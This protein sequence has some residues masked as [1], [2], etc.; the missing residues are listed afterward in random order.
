MI[1]VDVLVNQIALLGK[2]FPWRK[3]SCCPRCGVIGD[4]VGTSRLEFGDAERLIK[5]KS[6]QRWN[7]PHSQRT[8][9]AASTIRSW[10]RRYRRSGDQL[11]ST[12][13]LSLRSR[14]EKKDWWGNHTRHCPDQK[15]KSTLPVADLIRF[16]EKNKLITSGIKIYPAT[17]YRILREEDLNRK[18]MAKIDRRRLEAKYYN[19]IWQ[20]DIMHGPQVKVGDRLRKSYLIAFIDDHSRLLPQAELYLNE[21]LSS[22]LDAFSK[23][24]KT[25]GFP[26]ASRKL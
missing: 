3:P 20:S 9:I 7:I 26:P 1:L 23:A 11:T 5:E 8:R 13:E 17:V 6:G 18:T 2:S 14:Q 4:L 10:V 16:L 12:A 15:K 25:R 21:R 24:L 19:D 22:W